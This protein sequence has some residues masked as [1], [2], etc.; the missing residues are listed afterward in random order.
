MAQKTDSLF[1]V[2]IDC[3]KEYCGIDEAGRGPIAGPLVVAGVI[4]K[5]DIEGLDDSKKLT[6]K[7][8]ENLYE[9]IKTNSDWFIYEIDSLTIDNI[10]LSKSIKEA[11]VA[12]KN[13]FKGSEFIFDGNTTFGVGNIETLIK[14]DQKLENVKAAS[15]LAKVY[16]DNKMIDFAK[17]YPLYGFEKHKGYGTKAHMEAVK[18]Y[19]LSPI[20]RKSFNF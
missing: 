9:V 13:N 17:Q 11:L 19:G 6:Q 20:H 3:Y 8:R 1:K 5:K 18:K 2:D 7:R 15:I 12:I 4:L 10:G 16:R 14:A